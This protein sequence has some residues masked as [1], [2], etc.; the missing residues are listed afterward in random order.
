[1]PHSTVGAVAESVDS[2]PACSD[3]GA[4]PSAVVADAISSCAHRASS[5]VSVSAA[6]TSLIGDKLSFHAVHVRAVE[7]VVGMIVG[8]LVGAAL[9]PRLGRTAL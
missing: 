8:T 7:V 5:A 3:S 4:T 2:Q 1:M 9:R 6:R